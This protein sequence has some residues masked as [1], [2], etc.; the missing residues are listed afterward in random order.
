VRVGKETTQRQEN[1]HDTVRHTEVQVENL[2]AMDNDSYFRSDWQTNYSK[3]GGSYDD[4]APAYGYGAEM[5]QKDTYRDRPWNEVESDLRS[6]WEARDTAAEST[7]EKFKA[8]IRHG[9]DRMTS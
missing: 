6:D 2:G 9:W 4:Y 3:L 7:W 8:A 1:I 5:A